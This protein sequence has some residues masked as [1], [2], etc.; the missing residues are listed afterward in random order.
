M[1]LTW[2]MKGMIFNRIPLLKKL[3]LRE[4]VCFNGVYGTLSE[5]N[6]PMN[7]PGLFAI[8]EGTTQLDKMPY[9]EV[10]VGLENIFKLLRLV[11]FQRITYRDANLSWMGKWG[12]LRFGIYADF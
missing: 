7:H 3:N 11:Y 5:K 8:P 12:G 6:N 4:I 1:N 10:G 9:M 2:H